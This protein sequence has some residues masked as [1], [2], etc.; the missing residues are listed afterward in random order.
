MP[1]L[2]R[3]ITPEIWRAALAQVVVE[4]P[5]PRSLLRVILDAIELGYAKLELAPAV[6]RELPSHA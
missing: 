1:K 5:A 6:L 2:K 4:P 3:V